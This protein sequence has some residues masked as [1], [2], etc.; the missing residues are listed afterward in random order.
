L[1]QGIDKMGGGVFPPPILGMEVFASFFKKKRLAFA[2]QA[3]G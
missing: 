2:Y 3:V 1:A